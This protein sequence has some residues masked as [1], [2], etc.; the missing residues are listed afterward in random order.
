LLLSI[1]R[2]PGEHCLCAEKRVSLQH[3]GNNRYSF[4]NLRV[5]EGTASLSAGLSFDA[6][7]VMGLTHG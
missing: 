4:T 7:P 5:R 3:P 6:E 1:S 2:H